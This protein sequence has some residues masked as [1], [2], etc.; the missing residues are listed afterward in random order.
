MTS[1]IKSSRNKK[2][3]LKGVNKKLELMKMSKLLESLTREIL[4]SE[5]ER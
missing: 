2:P 1:K 5:A 4:K 3:Q